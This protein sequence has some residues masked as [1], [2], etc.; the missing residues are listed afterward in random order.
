MIGGG[1]LSCA[2]GATIGVGFGALVGNQVA[3]VVG[4]L[5]FFFVIEPLAQLVWRDLPK[6]TISQAS[7]SLGSGGSASGSDAFGFGGSVLV[8]LVWAAAM[9]GLG[10]WRE[11]SREVT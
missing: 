6:F 7:G 2:L 8:L 9:L 5:V 4:S 11:H 3:G 1:L 10:L